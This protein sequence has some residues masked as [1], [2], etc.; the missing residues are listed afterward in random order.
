M[1]QRRLL[2]GGLLLILGIGIVLVALFFREQG[3]RDGQTP[4]LSGV[5]PDGYV[6]WQWDGSTWG[7]LGAAPTC[8]DDLDFQLPVDEAVVTG[9][10]YP[11]QVRGEYKPHG[12]LRFDS[13][14]STDVTVRAP[15]DAYATRAAAYL[16][17]GE[18]QY[19]IDFTLPCGILY[20]FDHLRILSPKLA[21]AVT[22]L[23]EPAELDSRTYALR[24]PL[25]IEQ[26]EVVA[27]AAG[28]ITQA[29]VFIDVGVY[30]VRQKNVASQRAGWP[31]DD[32]GWSELAP[33]ALC[34]LELLPEDLEGRL[35]ALP[36]GNE[37]KVS[38]YC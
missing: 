17:G 20:R 35:R 1:T 18:I 29:N 4:G 11:G 34:W 37:G 25:L 21:A 36:S 7:A 26:G 9:V 22:H 15:L 19:M 2:L 28:F 30:D 8:A 23:P 33:Y 31:S 5:A 10:L 16:S 14:A 6:A 38:D 3:A 32:H 24:E 27:T 13:S 12:G